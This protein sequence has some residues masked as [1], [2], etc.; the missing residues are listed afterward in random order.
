MIS[1]FMTQ[2]LNSNTSPVEYQTTERYS[3]NK[4][5]EWEWISRMQDIFDGL[6]L[7]K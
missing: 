2:G 7:V 6:R 4:E 3:F 5:P 1:S